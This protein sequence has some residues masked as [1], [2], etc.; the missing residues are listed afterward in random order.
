MPAPASWWKKI[1]NALW[2]RKNIQINL[3]SQYDGNPNTFYYYTTNVSDGYNYGLNF[4]YTYD[5]NKEFNAYLKIGLLNVN[6]KLIPLGIFLK[7]LPSLKT[8][9]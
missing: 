3:S 9:I 6:L 5:I 7:M 8:V 2:V 4:D 1:K